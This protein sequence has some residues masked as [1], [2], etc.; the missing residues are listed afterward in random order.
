MP[1]PLALRDCQ[2]PQEQIESVKGES[3][4]GGDQYMRRGPRLTLKTKSRK[5]SAVDFINTIDPKRTFATPNGS[6]AL[7]ASTPINVLS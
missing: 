5:S 4:K 2:L 1:R 7:P 3:R 6:A